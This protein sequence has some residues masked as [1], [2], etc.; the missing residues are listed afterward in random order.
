MK[1]K[2]NGGDHCGLGWI[3]VLRCL[4]TLTVFVSATWAQ[5]GLTS[6]ELVSLVAAARQRYN[7]LSAGVTVRSYKVEDGGSKEQPFESAD[8]VRRWTV[9]KG[10]AKIEMFEGK[11][12]EGVKWIREYAF[13]ERCSKRLE[14]AVTQPR[15]RGIIERG[16]AMKDE[17]FLGP[18]AAMFEPFNRA[19]LGMVSDENAEVSPGD[20]A[21]LYVLQATLG[22]RGQFTFAVEVDA[23]KGWVPTRSSI[24]QIAS[25]KSMQIE[26]TDFRL[27]SEA[28]WVPFGYSWTAPGKSITIYTVK[29]AKV[30]SDIPDDQLDVSFPPG[31]VV[32]DR[33]ANLHYVLQEEQDKPEDLPI[34]G[35]LDL[36]EEGVLGA[37][38]PLTVENIEVTQPA[39]DTQ[40]EAAHREAKR[41]GAAA[42]ES[43]NVRTTNTLMAVFGTVVLLLAGGLALLWLRRTRKADAS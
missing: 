37:R 7:S 9:D 43:Q 35:L 42:P 20:R 15:P 41:L 16:L 6:S 3:F 13:S 18:V 10:Y 19:W 21:N 26:C 25:G 1:S 14:R 5:E 11:Q 40:L 34:E 39:T 22:S 17:L 30:N 4:T 33:I 32:D 8:F 29:E 31:T 28:L 36:E 2:F 23:A 38:E 12:E 27:V 24:T